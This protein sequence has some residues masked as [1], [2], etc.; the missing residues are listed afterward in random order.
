M[1]AVDTRRAGRFWWIAILVLPLVNPVVLFVLTLLS[2]GESIGFVW[3]ASWI[4]VANGVFLWRLS[5]GVW[6]APERRRRRVALGIAID[7]ALSFAF[8]AGEVILWLWIV[9]GGGGCWS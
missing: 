8:G 1:T 6:R 4:G 5:D 9:C 7:I 2:G 3:I